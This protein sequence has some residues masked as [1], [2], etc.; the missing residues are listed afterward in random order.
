MGEAS[1]NVVVVSADSVRHWR[2]LVEGA[3]LPGMTISLQDMLNARSEDRRTFLKGLAA[4]GLGGGLLPL[5]GCDRQDFSRTPLR[6]ADGSGSPIRRPILIP[7]S[8]DV[9]RIAA[10]ASELPVA[11]VSMPLRQVF[12]DLEFRDRAS[13]L[14]DA[15]ISV[16]TG[17][18]RV[19]LPG[20]PVGQPITPGDA[21]REFEEL[22]IRDWNPT[23][24]AAENDIRILRGVRVTRQVDFECVP[25]VRGV[26]GVGGMEWYSAGPWTLD[27][28][29][30]GTADTTREDFM[31]V[32][33]GSRH[34]SRD[35]VEGGDSVRFIT[36]ACR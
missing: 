4:F 33:S 24:P 17:H 34:A 22:N 11:Y 28:C 26:G 13:W 7:W 23:R 8:D 35:C 16:S 31:I 1:S 10:P 3:N 19:P 32:G 36:W 25:G 14:L 9:A 29:D 15:H 21:L 2:C 30:G 5:A 6:A 18:W 12:V 27:V 20:D